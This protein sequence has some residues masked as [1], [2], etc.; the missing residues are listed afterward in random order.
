M[1]RHVP[2]FRI[3]DILPPKAPPMSR[4][5]AFIKNSAVKS[6]F[7]MNAE[8]STINASI[9]APAAAPAISPAAL[10]SFAEIKPPKKAPAASRPAEA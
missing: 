2:E 4:A 7:P 3:K 6:A 10:F 1:E 9:A 5:A 8:T